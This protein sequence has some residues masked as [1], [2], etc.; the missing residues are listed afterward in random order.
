MHVTHEKNAKHLLHRTIST[1]YSVKTPH[2]ARQRHS[3]TN[4]YNT[5][6]K[7]CRSKMNTKLTYFLCSKSKLIMRNWWH[8]QKFRL[9]HLKWTPE[10]NNPELFC[11][12]SSKR[13]FFS[14][15]PTGAFLRSCPST[16]LATIVFL[17]SFTQP[18]LQ[19]HNSK[20]GLQQYY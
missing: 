16:S 3:L 14:I 2:R 12:N 8:W 18:M 17:S 10:Q 11:L 1:I 4:S 20:T 5:S 15:A 9:V 6:S 19:C 7:H 13:S